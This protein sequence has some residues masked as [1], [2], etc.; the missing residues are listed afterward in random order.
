MK[1]KVISGDGKEMAEEEEEEEE[2]DDE[3]DEQQHASSP[4]KGGPAKS[5]EKKQKAETAKELSD[6]T[7]IKSVHF[8]GWDAAKSMLLHIAVRH[9]RDR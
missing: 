9:F 5:A 6:I 7:Y 3:E 1:G 2:E 4:K 8:K